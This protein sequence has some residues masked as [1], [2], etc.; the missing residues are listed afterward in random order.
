[1]HELAPVTDGGGDD[2]KGVQ[3]Q[4]RTVQKWA[5]LWRTIIRSGLDQTLFPYCRY[6]R[7]LNLRDLKN[8][9]EDHRFEGAIR[10]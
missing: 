5:L 3:Q 9:F 4:E 8:L 6:I 2:V 7:A 10:E 1:M